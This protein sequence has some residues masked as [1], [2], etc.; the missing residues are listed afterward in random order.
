M[1]L[2]TFATFL[3]G[4]LLPCAVIPVLRRLGVVDT[5]NERSS[6]VHTT[7]R[8]GGVAVLVAIFIGLL[9]TYRISSPVQGFTPAVLVA[10]CFAVFFLGAVG[11]VEDTVGLPVVVRMVFQ[12]VG[13]V[14]ATV[15]LWRGT[16]LPIPLLVIGALALV[17]TVNATNFMDGVNGLSSAH[18][19]VVGA[20][21]AVLGL[22]VHDQLLSLVSLIVGAAF[23]SFLPWNFP[24]ARAFLGDV[25]SYALGAAGW[26]LMVWALTTH[27]PVVVVLAPFTIYAVDVLSTL[28]ARVVRRESLTKAHRSHIYQQLSRQRGHGYASTVVTSATLACALVAVVAVA[29]HVPIVLLYIAIFC[30]SVLYL[31]WPIWALRIRGCSGVGAS[32]AG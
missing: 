19:A 20:Y 28:V 30:I 13:A 4:L 29:L 3:T 27:L 24:R 26:G 18:G 16:A 10:T 21:F 23:L 11:L 9:L 15:I 2:V 1:I 6:H 17:Y 31:L 14:S 5:P 12:L 25:G 32:L 8:G 22:I 7:V